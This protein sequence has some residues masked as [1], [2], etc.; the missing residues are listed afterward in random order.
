[1]YISL[2]L[3]HL[4]QIPNTN[5][6]TVS[7]SKFI[8]L[9]ILPFQLAIGWLHFRDTPSFKFLNPNPNMF[10]VQ[11]SETWALSQADPK[12]PNQF[13][14]KPNQFVP[15]N[16][17]CLSQTRRRFFFKN[18]A[19]L[20]QKQSLFFPNTEPVFHKT[21]PVFHKTEPVFHKTEPVHPKNGACFSQKRKLFF[22]RMELP[23]VGG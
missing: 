5:P 4:K 17:A 23:K 3:W 8:G 2:C 13:S 15:K 16:G 22:P 19:S 10:S 18:E 7:T 21:E 14:T 6:E 12:N 11:N 1:M 9:S 20:F